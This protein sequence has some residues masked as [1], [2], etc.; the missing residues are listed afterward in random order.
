[1]ET[2]A[3]TRTRTVKLEQCKNHTVAGFD[4]IEIKLHEM[5]HCMW[6]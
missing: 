6:L 1:M 4:E 2:K 5:L 3:S